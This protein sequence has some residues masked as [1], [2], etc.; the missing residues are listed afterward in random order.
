MTFASRCFW[1]GYMVLSM[2]GPSPFSPGNFSFLW[3]HPKIVHIGIHHSFSGA[4]VLDARMGGVSL[5]VVLR[6]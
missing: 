1:D 5:S 3:F 6:A 2:F 4:S